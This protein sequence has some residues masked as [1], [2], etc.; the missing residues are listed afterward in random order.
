M[1]TGRRGRVLIV[2]DEPNIRKTIEMIHRNAGWKTAFAGGGD[3]ALRLLDTETF[4]LVYMDMVMPGRDGID[5]LRDIKLRRPEQVVVILTG[6]ATIEKAVEAVK[7]GAFDFLE[8]DCGKEKILLKSLNAL[9]YR[10]LADENRVLR[11][12]ISKNREY[13]G[14]SA[15]AN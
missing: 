13:L 4:D 14:Q 8:K 6:Q 7:L 3:E 9:E 12:I 1:S 11:E 5:V 10:S 2:D 15:S